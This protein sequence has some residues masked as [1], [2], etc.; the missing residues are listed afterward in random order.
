MCLAPDD[1][2]GIIN[3]VA[4]DESFPR[5]RLTIHPFPIN[6]LKIG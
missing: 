6:I 5:R 1:P 2:E 3:V 4:S